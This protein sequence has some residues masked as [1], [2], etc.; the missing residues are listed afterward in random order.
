MGRH[1]LG[2]RRTFSRRPRARVADVQPFGFGDRSASVAGDGVGE[3]EGHD[4]VIHPPRFA[5]PFDRAG[6]PVAGIEVGAGEHRAFGVAFDVDAEAVQRPTEQHRARF[7]GV[8]IEAGREPVVV[9][10]AGFL[11]M[12]VAVVLDL[13]RDGV[14]PACVE[15]AEEGDTVR[16]HADRAADAARFVGSLRARGQARVEVIGGDRVRVAV[17]F[18]GRVGL[19]DGEGSAR[20][21]GGRRVRGAPVYAGSTN[22][23]PLSTQ[24]RAMWSMSKV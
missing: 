6:A 5:V 15:R 4:V 18:V 17:V 13:G 2:S 14:A 3:V 16:H 10:L 21:R 23:T 22:R 12:G 1:A 20:L 24:S 8:L 19:F 9:V 11:G 7:V